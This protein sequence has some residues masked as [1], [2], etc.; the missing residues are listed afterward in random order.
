MPEKPLEHKD[1][2]ELL[3]KLKDETPEYPTNLAKARKDSFLK[4]LLD[5]DISGSGQ[6]NRGSGDDGGNKGPKGGSRVSKTGGSGKPGKPGK[7]GAASAAGGSRK[8]GG[9]SGSGSSGGLRA[10][11][12][13]RAAGLGFGISL[14]SALAFGAAVVLLTAGYLFRDQIA[15]YLAENGIVRTEET[16]AP[17]SFASSSS[18][19]QD[20]SEK[21][22]VINT[23]TLESLPPG[24]AVT[25]VLVSPGLGIDNNQEEVPAT[26]DSNP[27]SLQPTATPPV[28]SKTPETPSSP[29]QKSIGERLRF[30]VCVLRNGGADGCE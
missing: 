26:G 9:L 30:L 12:G 14:K 28:P 16:A 29:P 3:G 7:P 18:A 1:I 8:P 22:S 25:E 19:G 20:D 13:G 15:D 27:E 23:P 4:Q 5:F 11:R 24:I 17:P 10:A 21:P 6:D 2:V